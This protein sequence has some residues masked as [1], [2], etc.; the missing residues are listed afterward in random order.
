MNNGAFTRLLP[1]LCVLLGGCSGA[2]NQPLEQI[3]E[4]SYTVD[5]AVKFSITNKDGT[6]RIYGSDAPELHVQTIKKAYSAARLRKISAKVSVQ[7][8]SISIATEFPPVS[9]WGLGDRSGTVDYIILL[10]QTATITRL[11]LESGEVAIEGIREG[12]VHARL[13]TGLMFE[14]NCFS[15]ADLAVTTGNLTVTYDWWEK[16]AFSAAA[17]VRHGNVWAFLPGEAAFHL[18]AEAA[19]GRIANDFAEKE[20]RH[21]EPPRKIDMIVHGGGEASLNVRADNGNIR[22]AETNP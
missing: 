9:G 22:I 8:D 19:R 14:H 11:E 6:I 12:A 2:I 18:S 13:G 20:D 16:I 10:P 3:N 5:P 21:A 1:L 4:V 17:T 15:N 7:P